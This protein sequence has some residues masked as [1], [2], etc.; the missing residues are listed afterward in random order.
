MCV[1]TVTA[2][3]IVV[4]VHKVALHTAIVTNLCYECACRKMDTFTHRF[5]ISTIWLFFNVFMIIKLINIGVL[6]LNHNCYHYTNFH[7]YD[8]SDL[9]VTS[10]KP[11]AI[12]L[13]HVATMLLFYILQRKYFNKSIYFLKVH[14]HTSYQ[15]HVLSA[16]YFVAT[17][18]VSVSSV[19][20]IVV[21]VVVIINSC[22]K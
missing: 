6:A 10:I 13:F 22:T 12:Y 20:V 17:L 14:H 16:T 21:V 5:E 4:V 1:R 3:L 15:D 7:M 9:F 19:V 2:V 11:K 18:Q 8:F